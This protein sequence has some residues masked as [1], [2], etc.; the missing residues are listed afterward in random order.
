MRVL[1]F[2]SLTYL[3]SACNARTLSEHGHKFKS[4]TTDSLLL[5]DLSAKT[6]ALNI[7]PITN[8]VD[9]FE[10]RIWHG[11]SIATPQWLVILK[12][13]DSAWLLTHTDYWFDY[14]WTNGKPAKVLLDSSFTKSLAVPSNI[15]RIVDSIR[16]LKLDTFPSQNEI[17]GF[18]DNVADGVFYQIEIAT[19]TFYKA[20]RYGNPNRYTDTNNQQMSKLITMLNGIGVF[21]MP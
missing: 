3:L 21:S 4:L 18:Q 15:F 8:G 7:S 20:V 5:Q 1:L 12:N 17:P 14:Q 11:L 6:K 10:L 19:P 13:Q 16:Q 9:S 2:L